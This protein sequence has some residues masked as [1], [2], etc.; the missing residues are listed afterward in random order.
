[1]ADRFIADKTEEQARFVLGV[2]LLG[3][4]A[5]LS[6]VGDDALKVL[7]VFSS[8]AGRAGNRGQSD[9][10]MANEVL[11]RVAS[12]YAAAHANTV[13]R[14]IGWGPW[15]GGMVDASLKA[16]FDAAGVALVGLQDGA[17][18]FVDEL[19]PGGDVELV[20]GGAPSDG[21]LLADDRPASAVFNVRVD[22][23]SHPW[24]VDHTITDV[25]V[26]PVVMTLEWFVRAAKAFRPELTVSAVEDVK[27]RR[28]VTLPHFYNGGD[29][30]TLDISEAGPGQL[31]VSLTSA[32]PRAP[33]GR[34]KHYDATVAVQPE[35]EERPKN[36]VA[37]SLDLAAWTDTIYG[38][39]LFHGP[40]FQ[41]ITG[42]DGVADNAIQGTLDGVVA[43]NWPSG[44]HTD[45][46]ALDGGIQL[47]VL[48]NKHAQGGAF[49][50][51]GIRRY[52]PHD[53]VVSGPIR[54]TVRPIAQGN[55][56]AVSDIEF[57]GL[58]GEPIASLQ[59]VQTNRRPNG[60]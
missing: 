52:V 8:V 22:K 15:A 39:V 47:A 26:L 9:Y 12:Q 11:N 5:L 25:P 28:G 58:N 37:P 16:R 31:A 32:D 19:T 23:A 13:V 57:V 29:V 10:A 3:L 30:F 34:A 50:P 46:A 48:W 38:D 27:V 6:A 60:L 43:K 44:F 54:C 56:A 59:G 42:L 7:A 24:L 41:V 49:L 33:G 18:R 55:D 21:A 53:P 4:E 17:R 1:L 51:T 36:A 14:S 40:D 2:K 35:P 45:A 20:I